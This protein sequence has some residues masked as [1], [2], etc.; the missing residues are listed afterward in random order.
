MDSL[1]R[2]LKGDYLVLGI[3]MIM[4]VGTLV[5]VSVEFMHASAVV[6]DKFSETLMVHP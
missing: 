1:L 4:A 6:M 3:I 5:W 2:F